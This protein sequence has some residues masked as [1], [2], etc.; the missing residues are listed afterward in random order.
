M[1][2]WWLKPPF[3]GFLVMKTTVWSMFEGQGS[4]PKPLHASNGL[5]AAGMQAAGMQATKHVISREAGALQGVAVV[6]CTGW[7]N[8][9]SRC[10]QAGHASDRQDKQAVQSI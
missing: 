3:W 5:Q 6:L 4:D 8:K 10:E 7:Q 1:Y 2:W 9:I